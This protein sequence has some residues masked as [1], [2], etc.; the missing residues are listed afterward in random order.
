[1]EWLSRSHCQWKRIFV[2]GAMTFG[3]LIALPLNARAD[4]PTANQKSISTARRTLI[5]VGAP[6]E[7]EFA[8]AFQSWAGRWKQALKTGDVSLLSTANSTET[9]VNDHDRIEAWVQECA[10]S[11]ARECWIVLIGHGT[12]D[13]SGAKFNLVGPDLT[14][15]ELG[16]WIK[17]SQST[18]EKQKQTWVIIDCASSS[19]PFVNGL[20]GS[21]RVIVTAT[22]SGSE[23]NYSRFGD[24]LSQAISDPKSDLDHDRS[25]SVLEA[26]LAASALTSKFYDDEGRLASEQALLD[27]N[28]DGKGTPSVFYRGIRPVKAPAEGLQLD[29]RLANRMIVS[30]FGSLPTLSDEAQR[31]I[32]ELESQLESLRRSKGEMTQR[33]YFQK[34]ESL[35]L[36]IA[37]LQKPQ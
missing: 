2:L 32:A 34:I 26:F 28:G 12:F 8:V 33:A 19:G 29:G 18:G 25:V 20:S 4:E 3:S 16:Q 14:S 10:T 21:D 11:E 30:S 9:K 31:R 6:G 24:Y 36:E 7:E 27:D 13:R 23:M 17:A 22:K 15:A 5:V 37:D 1:M 35:L